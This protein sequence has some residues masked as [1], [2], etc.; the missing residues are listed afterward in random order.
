MKIAIDLVME[1]VPANK[2]SHKASWLYMWASQL[3]NEGHEV[4]VLHNESWEGYDKIYLWQNSLVED[5]TINCFGGVSDKTVSKLRRLIDCDVSK[6][7]ALDVKMAD[8]GKFVKS[9]LHNKSMDPSGHLVD[10][11]KVTEVCKGIPVVTQRDLNVTHQIIG[12]SHSFSVYTKGASL[13]RND[14]K[15]LNGALNQGLESFI[16]PGMKKLTFYFGNIDI[17]HHVC[18][19]N[20]GNYKQNIDELMDRYAHQLLHLTENYEIELIDL[21]PIES[22]SR[23]IPNSIGRYKGLQFTGSHAQRS[24]AYKYFNE[25]LLNVA[26]KLGAEI[27]HHPVH[28]MNSLGELSFSVMEPKQNVHLSRQEYRWDLDNDE[29]RN[30]Q[31]VEKLF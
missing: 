22:E 7:V 10:W 23:I 5:F 25:R 11:D 13:S 20:D 6:L 9:R 29:K 24:D 14:G 12:D 31:E 2:G 1:N 30:F 19:L 26:Q 27:Y 15:T 4:K 18:R 28:Y 3:R 16:Y 8:Y 17:R 21:L